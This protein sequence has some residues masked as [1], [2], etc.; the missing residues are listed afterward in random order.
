[1]C[2]ELGGSSENGQRHQAGFRDGK[3]V[4]GGEEA[5]NDG[6][7]EDHHAHGKVVEETEPHIGPEAGRF[8]TA[9]FHNSGK[10]K[11]WDS[12]DNS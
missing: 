10:I 12:N 3:P 7:T 4:P 5:E 8:I 6:I 2:Y 9:F 11:P 1:V